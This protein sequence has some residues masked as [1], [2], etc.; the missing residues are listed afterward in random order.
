MAA[1]CLEGDPPGSTRLWGL[2][3]QSSKCLNSS[4]NLFQHDT[5]I[6]KI[7]HPGRHKKHIVTIKKNSW[8]PLE[9][10]FM[11]FIWPVYTMVCQCQLATGT[12]VVQHDL[13]SIFYLITWKNTSLRPRWC[14][15]TI[16]REGRRDR[17]TAAGELFQSNY[18]LRKH[19]L[20]QW[21]N[22]KILKLWL[23]KQFMVYKA[24]NSSFQIKTCSSC[25]K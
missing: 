25:L 5:P 7:Y 16:T 2:T 19:D 1:L 12:Q 20:C 24:L 9:S 8:I 18:R 17:V 23:N 13:T 14:A 15:F 4:H 22:G 11:E 6:I 21:Y 3:M 10:Q